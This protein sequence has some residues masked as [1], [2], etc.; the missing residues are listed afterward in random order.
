MNTIIQET[1]IKHIIKSPNGVS[2]EYK[3]PSFQPEKVIFKDPDFLSRGHKMIRPEQLTWQQLSPNY[4]TT[5]FML[6]TR[7]TGQTFYIKVETDENVFYL[8]QTSMD[9]YRNPNVPVKISIANGTLDYDP[10]VDVFTSNAESETVV[11]DFVLLAGQ[12]E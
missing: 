11:V 2:T 6:S 10:T 5:Y 9:C 3:M 4:D 7:N 8:K 1:T 12:D